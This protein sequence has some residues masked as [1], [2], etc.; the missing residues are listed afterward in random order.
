MVDRAPHQPPVSRPRIQELCGIPSARLSLELLDPSTLGRGVGHLQAYFAQP[1]NTKQV[2]RGSTF[3]TAVRTPTQS[4]EVPVPLD[5][6]S[7]RLWFY[8]YLYDG[9]PED[10]NVPVLHRQATG[11]CDLDEASVVKAEKGQEPNYTVKLM[12]TDQDLDS[13]DATP[14]ATLRF[15]VASVSWDGHPMIQSHDLFELLSHE[16][17]IK[18]VPPFSRNPNYKDK[19]LINQYLDRVAHWLKPI[20]NTET[21]LPAWT[22]VYEN[23]AT[24][25]LPNW[26]FLLEYCHP[27]V[28]S[29][30][31]TY[32]SLKRLA[33]VA[34]HMNGCAL[35]S[36]SQWT[37]SQ[38]LETL[39]DT[40]ALLPLCLHYTGDC[41]RKTNTKSDDDD[42]DDDNKN[43]HGPRSWTPSDFVQDDQWCHPLASPD[44]PREA[45]DCE[46]GSGTAF[47][48]LRLLQ[49]LPS[50]PR[51]TLVGRLQEVAK[52]YV[53]FVAIVSLQLGDQAV[54]HACPVLVDQ[55]LVYTK[56]KTELKCHVP[57]V[58]NRTPLPTMLVETTESTTACSTFHGGFRQSAYAKSRFV[59]GVVHCKVPNE[60]MFPQGNYRHVI[61]LMCPH[62][63][64]TTGVAELFC[65]M[66]SNQL[67]VPVSM[68]RGFTGTQWKFSVPEVVKTD[69]FDA[70]RV[71]ASHLPR[72]RG[73]PPAIK[74]FHEALPPFDP[75]SQVLLFS[76][77]MHWDRL[78]QSICKHASQTGKHIQAWRRIPVVDDFSLSMFVITLTPSAVS[79]PYLT[80]GEPL[81]K[82]AVKRMQHRRYVMEYEPVQ[83][84]YKF[85]R[86]YHHTDRGHHELMYT[87]HK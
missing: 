76:S 20:A 51:S 74:S 86:Q 61:N 53:G 66:Q 29:V 23:F 60:I 73:L 7:N 2:E 84:C 82:S 54:Y 4:L 22:V 31:Q 46:D 6:C 71:A 28:D 30:E 24:G 39:A 85:H 37:E 72:V 67:G 32:T 64:E 70:C 5:R 42:D 10:P 33:C 35:T 3:L 36:L 27:R 16:L 87:G 48:V 75:R 55:G 19:A 65:R 18:S 63:Y 77:S 17:L 56:M 59:D 50:L 80:P 14:W 58:A 41:R 57:K 52:R 38:V 34:S 49:T 43:H 47:Y 81:S 62:L 9:S 25:K 69:L 44:P 1:L 26:A 12:A 83:G 21:K 13:K 45:Y 68:F 40:M 8:L 11:Y 78:S 15:Q 79:G